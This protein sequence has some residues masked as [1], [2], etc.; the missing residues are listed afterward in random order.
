V[1][2]STRQRH[3]RK[4]GAKG[5]DMPT[6]R[7]VQ[8]NAAK[9]FELVER[10][11]PI[12]GP[13]QV[14]VRVEACG[15]CHSDVVV[16]EAAWPGLQLPRIPGHEVAGV[17]DALGEG[18][19]HWNVGQRVGV[20]WFGGN[21]GRCDPCRAGDFIL[22]RYLQVAGV[23][24]DGGYAEYMV[25]PVAALARIPDDLSAVDAAPL[26]CAGVTTFNPLRH[27]GARP[28]DLVAIQGIGGLGHLAVQYAAKMGYRTAAIARGK[29]KEAEARQLG[30]H[31][32]L[33]AASQNVGE[34]LQALGGARVILTTVTSSE[35]MSA[36]LSGLAP[37]G[38]MI[39][40]GI[41]QEPLQVSTLQIVLGR[42]AIQG[43]PSGTSLDS[44]DTMAFSAQQAVRAMIETMPLERAA[45]A[46]ERMMNGKARFRVVLK[47]D[48]K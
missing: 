40:V 38:R 1:A 34:A 12:P 35:A 13:G 43:W 41:S 8:V 24:Y 11:V 39:I 6:M 14:R 20:G 19:T 32:Y 16:K 17:I 46:Y 3:N 30:A 27:S 37:T 31:H 45:E 15:V 21:C 36:A 42:Q 5:V 29:D 28:G 33:D 23:S 7:A 2:H 48:M 4:P 26:L 18:V 9:E 47:M 22:C 10:D 44:Q 25:A